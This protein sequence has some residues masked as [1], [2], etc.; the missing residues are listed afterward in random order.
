VESD[1][2]AVNSMPSGETTGSRSERREPNL[3]SRV[4]EREIDLRYPGKVIVRERG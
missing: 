4:P 1:L 3:R 2:Q